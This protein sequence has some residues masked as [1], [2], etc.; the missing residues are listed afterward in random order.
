M[1]FRFI[2][3]HDGTSAPR[4]CD[5]EYVLVLAGATI[6]VGIPTWETLG[7]HAVVRENQRACGKVA[8]PALYS[9]S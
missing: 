1:L 8:R 4:V 3:L 7:K 9:A 6:D 5:E 2:S